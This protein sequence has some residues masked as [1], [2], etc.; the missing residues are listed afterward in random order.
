MVGNQR[1]ALG[2]G[3]KG[4]GLGLLRMRLGKEIEPSAGDKCSTTHLCLHP[5]MST[6][7]RSLC[8]LMGKE[9]VSRTGDSRNTGTPVKANGGH[10]DEGSTVTPTVHLARS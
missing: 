5:Q 8:T 7:G 3:E 1:L 10:Q 6:C 9:Q 2:E 4:D